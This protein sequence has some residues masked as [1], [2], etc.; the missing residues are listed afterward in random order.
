MNGPREMQSYIWIN[1]VFLS[2]TQV[3]RSGGQ[4]EEIFPEYSCKKNSSIYS[5][6]LKEQAQRGPANLQEGNTKL[7][8]IYAEIKQERGT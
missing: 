8:K 2:V 3:I 6:S 5:N 1:V 4:W 7:M